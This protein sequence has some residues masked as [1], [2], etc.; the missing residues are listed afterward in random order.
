MK[1]KVGDK[2][3][4]VSEKTGFAWNWAGKMD[5]W[6]GK[7]MTIRGISGNAYRMQEDSTEFDGCGWYWGEE[8]ISGLAETPESIHITRDGNFVQAVHK[9][10][11]EIIQRATAKCSPSDTFDFAV[12]AELAFQRLMHPEVIKAP[13]NK[14]EG[15]SDYELSD[16]ICSD[17]RC[18]NWGSTGKNCPSRPYCHDGKGS[19]AYIL[20]HRSEAISY[21]LAEDEAKAKQDKPSKPDKPAEKHQYKVGDRITAN[22]NIG[23]S[24][25]GPG[26][27]VE[28]D[29]SDSCCTYRVAFDVNH[30]VHVWAYTD[31]V[32]PIGPAQPEPAKAEPVK[33]YCIKDYKPGKWL[34]KG[35]VYEFV[36][37]VGTTYDSGFVGSDGYGGNIANYAKCNPGFW[38]CLVPLVK[39][40]AKKGEYII[41]TNMDCI[42]YLDGRFDMEDILRVT[43][44]DTSIID[45]WK[46]KAV[47]F[48]NVTHPNRLYHGC[49]ILNK[50]YLVLDGYQPEPKQPEPKYWSGKVVCVETCGGFTVGGVYEFKDGKVTDDDGDA[51]SMSSY[52]AESLEA[53]NKLLGSG[54]ARFIEFKGEAHD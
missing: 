40:P 25:K 13:A 19:Y 27:I 4:I 47:G 9:R 14:Y 24:Y 35:K 26:T 6:L 18:D 33:L 36:P 31:S 41:V 28:V 29:E 54:I 3:R 22:S 17:R 51:R 15:M 16:A 1:Y 2:V 7:V 49:V 45:Q 46:G 42:A 21:L 34:T 20:E 10:G 30:G 39:R 37:G 12:G 44:D 43:D 5:K 53:W 50:D 11:D 8:M 23:G 48:E 32:K 52:R 38:S